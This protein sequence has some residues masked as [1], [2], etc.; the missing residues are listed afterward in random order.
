MRPAPP[1]HEFPVNVLEAGGGALGS[2]PPSRAD[3]PDGIAAVD[4]VVHLDA[5]RGPRRPGAG[6]HT[7]GSKTATRAHSAG[8]KDETRPRQREKGAND[9]SADRADG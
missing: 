9:G 6:G 5:G 4:E 1:G 8:L 7:T 3:G 2:S